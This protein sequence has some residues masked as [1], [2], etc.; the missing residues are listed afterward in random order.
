MWVSN[1]C[2]AIRE[3]AFGMACSLQR[4]HGYIKSR[5]AWNSSA[6]SVMPQRKYSGEHG[7]P[8]ESGWENKPTHY[9][10]E[11][12]SCKIW[13][14]KP[15]A[16]LREKQQCAFC[17]ITQIWFTF[18]EHGQSYLSAKVIWSGLKSS[19][20]MEMHKMHLHLHTLVSGKR[21]WGVHSIGM[22]STTP[23]WLQSHWTDFAFTSEE[24]GAEYGQKNAAHI[25]DVHGCADFSRDGTHSARGCRLKQ[26]SCDSPPALPML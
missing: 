14:W 7:V 12:D 4:F 17:L 1:I 16:F 26:S 2:L 13:H 18:E 20:A 5:W 19:Q 11:Q 8:G 21:Q 6:Y 23:V 10:Y 25:L 24:L 9:I 15:Q 22:I 3:S